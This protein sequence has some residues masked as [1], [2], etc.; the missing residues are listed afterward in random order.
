LRVNAVTSHEPTAQAVM[1]EQNARATVCEMRPEAALAI[2][3]TGHRHVRDEI[4]AA[5]EA[6]INKLLGDLKAAS[7]ATVTDESRYF[8]PLPPRLRIL[9]MAAEG[10]DLLGARAAQTVGADLNLIFPYDRTEYRHDFISPAALASFDA[11][12]AAARAVLELPG[13]REEGPRAYER[14]NEFILSQAN[15]LIAVWDGSRASGR[16]GTGDVVQTAI[17]ARIPVIVIDPKQQRLPEIL[18]HPAIR[19]FE[20]PLATDLSRRPLSDSLR[21]L[22]DGLLLP[23]LRARRHRGF[24]DLIVEPLKRGF[25]RHEYNL[26]LKTFQA[27]P[28]ARMRAIAAST[29]S[30]DRWDA[31]IQFARGIDRDFAQRM[32]AMAGLS[33]RIDDLAS[34]YSELYRSSTVTRFFVVV[35]V[36]FIAAVIGVVFPSLSGISLVAQIVVNAVVLVDATVSAVRRWQ[37]RWLDYRWIAER[38]RSLRFLQIL[39]VI[40]SEPYNPFLFAPRSWTTWYVERL[41]VALG[42]PNGCLRAPDLAAAQLL[43]TDII[44]QIEYHRR[45]YRARAALERRLAATA[46]FALYAAIAVGAIL[47]IAIYLKGGVRN[48]SGATLAN[49]LLS[50]LPAVMTAARGYRADADL[51]RLT[52]RSAMTAAALSTVRRTLSATPLT[53]DR[54][55][56]AATHIATVT[57]GELTEWRFVLESRGTRMLRRG[58]KTPWQRIGRFWERLISS[59]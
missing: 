37:E 16:G 38:L 45:V 9:T 49:L 30:G 48:V 22:T 21:D 53:I 4:A 26:F 29:I 59:R 19:E 46:S 51:I 33:R 31:A 34:Y 12:I 20:P 40:Q 24:A 44:E 2:G 25:R 57:S 23:S 7:Q 28:T 13:T 3:I 10:A 43:T 39:G 11:A 1:K 42:I 54:V 5:V 8:L 41:A 47:G 15:L 36:T 58:G 52:E 27:R 56:V 55:R 6:Q 18:L 14:A 32:E 35:I 50:I 17:S